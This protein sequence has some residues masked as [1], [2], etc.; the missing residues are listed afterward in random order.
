M[1]DD[2]VLLSSLIRKGLR[3]AM[4]AALPF[5]LT[6]A[7]FPLVAPRLGTLAWFLLAVAF[8]PFTWILAGRFVAAADRAEEGR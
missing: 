7:I 4:G 1:S 2:D 3:L 8:Y 6:L 5:V